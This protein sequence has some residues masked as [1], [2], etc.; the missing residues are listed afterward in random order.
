MRTKWQVLAGDPRR[1]PGSPYTTLTTPCPIPP[2]N[3]AVEAKEISNPHYARRHR[4]EEQGN[5]DTARPNESTTSS[6]EFHV[7][8][9]HRI[10]AKGARP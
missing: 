10:L 2:P 9:T 7:P 3:D 5:K 1:T 4:A 6:E 8:E